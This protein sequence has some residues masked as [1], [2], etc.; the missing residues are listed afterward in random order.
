MLPAMFQ[1]AVGTLRHTDRDSVRAA[2]IFAGYLL[3]PG[4]KAAGL[5]VWQQSR[6]A[7]DAC[8]QQHG[9]QLMGAM[10]VA[11]AGSCPR[12][13]MGKLGGAM[14]ALVQGYHGAAGQWMVAVLGAA[15]YPGNM[16]GTLREEDKRVFVECALRQPALPRQRFEAM[17]QDFASICRREATGDT[18]LAYQM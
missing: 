18:L 6:G 4:E 9:E 17:I 14:Y 1:S 15:D 8:V 5:P 12:H 7:V 16:E 2:L 13:L 11:A 10:L 3:A